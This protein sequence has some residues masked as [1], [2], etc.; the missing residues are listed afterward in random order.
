MSKFSLIHLYSLESCLITNSES[1]LI[2]T[3]FAPSSNKISR[4]AINA[5]YSASL[6]EQNPLILNLNLVGIP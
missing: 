5:S 1:P 3:S 2:A 4:P 6:L